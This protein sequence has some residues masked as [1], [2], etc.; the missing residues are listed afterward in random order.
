MP[1]CVLLADDSALGTQTVAQGFA[2]WRGTPVIDGARA[3]RS[4]WGILGENLGADDAHACAAAFEAVGIAT[5]TLALPTPPPL[6][7]PLIVRTV[8]AMTDTALDLVT[9]TGR[10]GTVRFDEL[11][12][13]A[14]AV[15]V[16]RSVRTEETTQGPS[17]GAKLVKTGITMAT[18]I[19]LGGGKTKIVEREVEER[20][21][22]LRCD[23]YLRA[24]GRRVRL[25]VGALN[26]S[27]LGAD[28]AYSLVSNYRTLVRRI[29]E[30][31]PAAKR[32]H[33]ASLLLS[34]RANAKAGYES[35]GDFERECRWRCALMGLTA[36]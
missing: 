9:D 28:K 27:F 23:L 8:N 13:V 17:L 35:E 5:R 16:E 6:P 15:L 14:T 31:A 20:R 10:Q 21:E 3:A 1:S 30:R 18:G 11:A 4:A 34:G 22:V 12:L 7:A 33:E 26:F 25:D 19:P 2:R 29:V 32:N 36:P 24:V